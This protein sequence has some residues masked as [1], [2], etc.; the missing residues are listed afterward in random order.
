[1]TENRNAPEDEAYKKQNIPAAVLLEGKFSSLYKNRISQAILDTMTLN[2]APLFCHNLSMD[3]KM[4]VVADGD[5]VLNG[6]LQGQPL[7]MG[8][9]PYTVETQYQYQFA[10]KQFVENCIEY[11]VNDAGLSEAR[12]KD[13]T[14]RLLDPKK[15]ANQKTMWQI[16]NIALPVLLIILFGI[17]YQWW[18]RRKYSS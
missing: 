15:V 8:V 6:V 5:I 7:P 16:I 10:N 14:L 12:A 4:I 1:M 2:M 17:T 3:N 18:R 13:Y 11:L 9:N